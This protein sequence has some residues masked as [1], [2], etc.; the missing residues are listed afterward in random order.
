MC[1]TRNQC[2]LPNRVVGSDING[3]IVLKCVGNLWKSW[4]RFTPV[5]V[6]NIFLFRQHIY[7]CRSFHIAHKLPSF[8]I[9]SGDALSW[10]NHCF[11][12]YFMPKWAT[13][14]LCSRRAAAKS[15]F[16]LTEYCMSLRTI[17]LLEL[18]Q[19]N[20]IIC[21]EFSIGILGPTQCGYFNLIVYN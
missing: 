14:F 16:S 13:G 8:V 12:K 9:A 5:V 15:L 10:E 17:Q 2:H 20:G 21:Q 7:D 18:N 6:D 3:Y 1:G 19:C 4:Y 11:L